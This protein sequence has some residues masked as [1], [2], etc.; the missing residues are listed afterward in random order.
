MLRNLPRSQFK[1]E[2]GDVFGTVASQHNQGAKPV[3]WC[4]IKSFICPG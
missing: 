2:N 1:N 4:L 3:A